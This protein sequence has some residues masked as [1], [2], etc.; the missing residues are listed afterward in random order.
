MQATAQMILCARQ[1]RIKIYH[2]ARRMP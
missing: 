1:L 2:E